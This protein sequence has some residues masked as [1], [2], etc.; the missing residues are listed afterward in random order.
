MSVDHAFINPPKNLLITRLHLCLIACGSLNNS[1]DQYLSLLKLPNEDLV[2]CGIANGTKVRVVILNELSAPT[3]R[4]WKAEG[5]HRCS[6]CALRKCAYKGWLRKDSFRSCLLLAPISHQ[7]MLQS[8][9]DRHFERTATWT[10]SLHFL[11]ALRPCLAHLATM[12]TVVSRQ[13]A[14]MAFMHRRMKETLINESTSV[15]SLG[16]RCSRVERKQQLAR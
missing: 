12:S 14:P 9:V 4:R 16:A 5:S 8:G 6:R 13:L 15:S 1:E 3:S 2:V 7:S 11:N 10:P